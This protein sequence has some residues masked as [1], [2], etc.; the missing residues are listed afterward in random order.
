MVTWKQE[1]MWDDSPLGMSI[2]AREM[3]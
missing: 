1:W 3:G 2:N